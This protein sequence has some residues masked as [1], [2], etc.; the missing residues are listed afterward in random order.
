MLPLFL[1]LTGRR[2][3]LV[4]EGPVADAKRQ[5]LVAAG[6]DVLEVAPSRFEPGQLDD[7]WLVVTTADADVNREVA[8]A[9]EARRIF[10]NAAD[11][12]PNASA[13]LSGVVQRGG[14]TIAISTEGAAPGL[15]GLLRE[16]FDE[17]LPDEIAEWVEE[18]RHLRATWRRDAV[19]FEA[20]RPLLLKA[21]NS[22]YARRLS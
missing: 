17:L 19:P 21:L 16:A 13:Y 2:V 7:A 6:A 12:P 1:N 22:R 5:L 15:T 10:I 8:R 18:A 9:A 3:V 11:D 14:V 4:G 20:R